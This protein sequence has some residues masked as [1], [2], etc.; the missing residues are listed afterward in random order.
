MSFVIRLFNINILIASLLKAMKNYFMN[1]MKI[2]L[3][4]RQ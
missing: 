2:L 1:I 3:L 4:C